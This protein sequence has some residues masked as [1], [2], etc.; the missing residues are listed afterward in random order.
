MTTDEIINDF[1][2][3]MLDVKFGIAWE[4]MPLKTV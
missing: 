4:G 3:D 2:F 1:F